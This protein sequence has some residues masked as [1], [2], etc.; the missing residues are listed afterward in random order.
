MVE[1]EVVERDEDPHTSPPRENPNPPAIELPLLE[2]VEG[3]PVATRKSSRTKKTRKVFTYD[4]VG[5][6]PVLAEI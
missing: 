3:S 6:P 1:Q 5:G 4:E 2:D